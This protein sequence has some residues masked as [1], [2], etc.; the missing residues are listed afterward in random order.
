MAGK[1]FSLTP[2]QVP[3]VETAYRRIVT[4]LPVPES[5]P[6]LERLREVESRSMQGQPPLV[7]HKAQ[8]VQVHDC[9]GNM[10]LDF[11]SG[12]LVTNVGHA[13]T[14]VI[15]AIVRTAQKPHLHHYCFPS[16]ERVA[17]AAK[18][19]ELAPPPLKK[20]FLLTTGAETTE[21]AFK[22]ARTYGQSLARRKIDFV[23]F[24]GSFHG[25]T[26]G[27]QMI[28]GNPAL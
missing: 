12:V 5:L 25:R 27:S 19:V 15:E 17:L 21:C 10:W 13:R 4:P 1:V 22:L 20:V 28:G 24:R 18:L 3:R 26:L 6:V 9:W 16:E 23:T 2:V 14:R 8:G 7:W 11:S